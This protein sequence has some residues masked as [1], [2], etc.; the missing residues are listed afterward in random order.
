MLRWYINFMKVI[1]VILCGGAGTRLW[2]E[3]KDNLPKQFVDWGGWTLFGKTLERV[4]NS[5]FDY[6][7]ITTNLNYWN[8]VKKHLLKHRIKKYRIILE[9]SKKNTAAAILSP[10]LL[11][12]IENDQPMVFFSADNLIDNV[13]KFNKSISIYK[14]H[15]D[16]D[17]IFIFGI[18]PTSF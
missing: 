1:P 11:K 10:A 8:L 3:S 2:P 14:Q 17:N 7:I 16:D 15:L 13:K 5:I 12:D 18:K 6:P 4:K 9:P